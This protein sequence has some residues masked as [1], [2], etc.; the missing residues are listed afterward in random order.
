MT[1]LRVAIPAALV[2]A[3]L[4]ATSAPA[5]E[6]AELLPPPAVTP[7][8][9]NC[10][11]T[12]GTPV[13]VAA[14]LA[15]AEVAVPQAVPWQT[16][17]GV[18]DLRGIFAGPR[19]APNG[20]EYHPNF[21]MDLDLDCWIWRG[22][23]IYLFGDARFWGEKSESGV[24]NSRDGFLG[25][26][27]RE[28]D[29]SGGAAWNYYG[30]W[31]ARFF[32]YSL[33]NLNRGNSLVSPEGFNDGFGMENRYY[34]SAEYASLG[35]IGYDVTRADF[36]SIGYYPSKILVGNDGR[37]F[38]PGLFLRAYLTQDLWNWPCY[39]FAD[40]TFLTDRSFQAKLMLFDLGLAARPFRRCPQ[41]EF[42]LGVENT[43]DF[44]VGNVQ[45]LWY[46]SVRY[47]F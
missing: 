21:S 29:F 19:T 22:Q 14:P 16:V 38:D 32:G 18:A 10:P 8:A 13:P 44:Q 39:A 28:F 1:D 35:Q 47:V 20:Q 5:Q 45:N 42:R 9:A 43:A 36:V 31:E 12:L 26:S 30:A 46:A 2:L 25:T 4:G 7:D 40:A 34:L 41:C 24:T 3:W 27:K 37:P 6:F 17:W 23:G 15:P 11:V 33:N